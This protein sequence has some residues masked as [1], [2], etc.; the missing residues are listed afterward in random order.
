ML[1]VVAR[2]VRTALAAAMACAGL[3]ALVS[4]PTPAAGASLPWDVG[5]GVDVVMQGQALAAQGNVTSDEGLSDRSLRWWY[6][7]ITNL[8][9][10]AVHIWL[11]WLTR[12]AGLLGVAVAA[13]MLDRNLVAQWRVHRW[14]LFQRY[15]PFAAA[16]YLLSV[17]DRRADR[18]GLIA[19]IAAVV[20]WIVGRDLIPDTLSI[21]MLDDVICIG[22]ASRWFMYRCPAEM[23]ERHA[24][25]VQK[26]RERT[27]RI[28]ARRRRPARGAKG[29]RP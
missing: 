2:S 15:V 25:S 10:L 8:L 27:S 21:G 4:A 13:S 11:G 28:Q 3:L 22:A 26:W 5:Q 29:D 14:R 9:R 23:I 12:V 17:F 1:I 20:Y 24:L 19:L 7:R 16:V 6:H 18:L